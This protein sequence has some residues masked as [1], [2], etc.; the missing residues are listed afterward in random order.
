MGW[1]DKIKIAVFGYRATSISYIEHLK[2]IGVRVGND[3]ILF[4]PMNTTIDIQNP[5]LLK[6]GSHVMITGPVTIL[7]H[8]YSWSVLKKKYGEILGNQ[9]E[10]VIEDNIFIGWG[11]TILAGSHIGSNSIIGAGSIVSGKLEGNAVYAGNPAH[12]IMSIED[13]YEKRK[14]KQLAEAVNYVKC[15]KECFGCNP[16]MDKMDEYFYLFFNPENG[17]QREIFNFKL[18]LMGNYE[19]T[20]QRAETCEPMFS[21]Y[22]EFIQYCENQDIED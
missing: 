14:K 22:N 4:R 18:G 15:Y 9:Q 3:V 1:K 13:Y 2:K 20:I 12:K 6:I 16:Q 8:D 10:T 11:A 19:E 17:E 21:S 7:T 5:H